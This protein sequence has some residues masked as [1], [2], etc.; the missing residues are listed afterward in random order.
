MVGRE[1]KEDL[2][3]CPVRAVRI[4]VVYMHSNPA[5]NRD[6]FSCLLNG[7]FAFEIHA[8]TISSWLKQTA[9][10]AYLIMPDL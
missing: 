9:G 10:L 5:F 3:L 1:D 2:L 8:N 7:V 4:Y 6:V